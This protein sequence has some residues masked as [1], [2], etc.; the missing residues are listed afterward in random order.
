MES[1]DNSTPHL[2]SVYDSKINSTIPYYECFHKEVLK[3]LDITIG[4]PR[5]WLDTGCGTGSLIEKAIDNFANTLFILADPSEGMLREAKL[6]LHKF[7][8]EK[9]KYIP[10]ATQYIELDESE[11]P[12]IITAIQAHHY[13][14]REERE[15]ATIKCYDLLRDGGI[16]ITFENIRPFTVVGTN[17]GKEYWKQFQI[18]CGKT[19]LEAEKHMD[20]FG[21]EYFPI[22]VEEHLS[23]LRKSGFKV[24]ELFW[25]SYM[26]AGFYCI[27]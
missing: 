22:T 11:R 5:I 14:S 4:N 9:I 6:K 26:Q 16:Y 21:V 17:N 12:D 27:K 25:Y 15:K 19:S 10:S 7:L 3:F 24:V 13:L 8:K 1:I 23:L 18:S 2:A 20:R